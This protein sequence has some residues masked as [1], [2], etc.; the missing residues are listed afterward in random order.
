M[1]RLP[2]SIAAVLWLAP[3]SPTGAQASPLRVWTARAFAT[4]LAEVGP[5]F[6]RAAGVTL[7][8][9]S[10]LPADFLRQTAA[11]ERFDLVISVA[12]PIDEWIGAGRLVGATRTDLAR[13]GI[14]VAVRAGAPKPDLRSVDAF[15][16][17]ILTTPSIAYL[18]VG[19]GLYLDS[20]FDRLHLADAVAARARR[21]QG[22]SVAILVAR[23]DVELGLVV[24]TQ[25][26]TTPGVA[27]AGPLPPALQSHVTF[28]AAVSSDAAAPE[29]ARQLIAFLQRPHVARVI[30]AQGMEGPAVATTQS[31]LPRF[32]RGD[33]VIDGDWAR[34]VRRECGWLV[35]PESRDHTTANTVRLAVEVFRALDPSG[36]PPLVL[37][38][39]GPGGPGAIRLYSQGIA[40]SAYPKHRDVVLYDQ[41][42]AGFSEPRLCPAYDRVA[43]SAYGLGASAEDAVLR[44]AR[45]A[46]IADLDAK[47]ID[48]LAYNTATSAADLVDLRRALSYA[49]WDVRGASYGAR[50]AQEAMLRDGQAI[51]AVVL[52]SPV[53]RA[54]PSRAEQPLSTQRALERVF[55]AC[56]GQSSC[57][58]AFPRLE[59]DF[60]DAYDE[61]TASPVPVPVAH[62]AGRPDTLWLDGARL[63]AALR[64]R[65]TERAGLARIPLLVHELRSGD[66]ARAARE[67]VG[68][69]SAPALLVGRA[70]RDLITCYDT[71]GSAYRRTLDSVNALARPPFRRGASREGCDEW[72]PRVG[73]PS[74]QAPVRS[75]IPTLITTGYFDDRTPTAYARRVAEMLSRAYVVELPGEGHDARPSPCHAAIVAQFLEDPT[76]KPDTSCVLTIPPILF[77]TTWARAEK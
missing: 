57:R 32:E 24:I 65:T 71:Y 49:S 29:A 41:R 6:E 11:G 63:V 36:A 61:L 45:R 43:D 39:G 9:V 38:H 74:M 67:I 58:D 35:V 52:A 47:G 14:G 73:D 60:Y 55:A 21:P 53:A 7:H 33:C 23:G 77:A 15:R 3:F 44:E 28:A 4:V 1:K 27:L 72:L 10:G 40:R 13:S 48:R 37:L 62:P 42:G 12:A 22:D 19:S 31:P 64:D 50:L 76:Q 46:C 26:L 5:E 20:L 17:A 66:R 30:M 25:I 68:E 51:R 54:F 69:G 56:A 2:L 59:Q 70:A 16:R 34:D 8:V 18:R 75:D